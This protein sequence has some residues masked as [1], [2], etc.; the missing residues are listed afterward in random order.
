MTLRLMP[1]LRNARLDALRDFVGASA[2]LKIYKETQP[3]TGQ[4]ADEQNLL[5]QMQCRTVAPGF[6][7]NASNGVSYIGAISPC[8]SALR[9]GTATWF[10]VL[11]SDGST[12]CFD[13]TITTSSGDGDLKLDDV[14]VVFGGTIAIQSGTLTEGNP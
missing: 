4:P 6:A 2:I 5:G 3:A 1:N 8:T 13:G 10:R 14:V 9:G 12:I 7:D 11:K